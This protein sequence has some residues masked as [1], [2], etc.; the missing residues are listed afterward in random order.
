MTMTAAKII[1]TAKRFL[2]VAENPKGSNNVQFNTDYYGKPVSG[3]AYPWCCVFVWDVFRIAGASDLFYNGKK[4]ASCLVLHDWGKNNGMLVP[5]QDARPGDIVF[6]DWNANAFADHV[7]ICTDNNPAGQTI[8]TIEGNTSDAVGECSH[9]YSK[10]C[11]ILRPAYETAPGPDC[12]ACP[13]RAAI[14][15]LRDSLKEV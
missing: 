6:Y 8:R 14:C 5:V 9:E 13:L 7:G 4:T 2:G 10:V 11:G 15:A 3:N 12:T 1:E